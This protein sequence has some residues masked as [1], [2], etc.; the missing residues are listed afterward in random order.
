MSYGNIAQ[1]ESDTCDIVGYP[2]VPRFT[3]LAQAT[4]PL[5]QQANVVMRETCPK[6]PSWNCSYQKEYNKQVSL[7]MYV[8]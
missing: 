5:M 6:V 2:A 7:Y 8:Y 1:S 3:A 4:V